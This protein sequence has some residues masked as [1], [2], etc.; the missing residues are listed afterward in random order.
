MFIHLV[1]AVHL[2]CSWHS[3][4]F[5]NTGVFKTQNYP[6]SRSNQTVCTMCNIKSESGQGDTSTKAG[7]GEGEPC[8]QGKPSQE[9]IVVIKTEETRAYF[10]K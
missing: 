6:P 3:F 7:G 1:V 10:K 2:L 5:A 8:G 4:C 9:G